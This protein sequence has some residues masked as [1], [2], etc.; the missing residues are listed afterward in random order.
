MKRDDGIGRFA[1]AEWCALST[2]CPAGQIGRADIAVA[3]PTI[4]EGRP[5]QEP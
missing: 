1:P 2:A 5:A 4:R 3:Q